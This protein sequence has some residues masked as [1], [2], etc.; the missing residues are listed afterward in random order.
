MPKIS[1][2][3]KKDYPA[4]SVINMAEKLGEMTQTVVECQAMVEITANEAVL[5]A[6]QVLAPMAKKKYGKKTKTENYTEED[7]FT[8]TPKAYEETNP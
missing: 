4:E 1:I 7:T 8:P 5:K 6:L 2:P 3:V